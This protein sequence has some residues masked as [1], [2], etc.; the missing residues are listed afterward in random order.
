MSDA[1]AATGGTAATESSDLTFGPR[2]ARAREALSLSVNDLAA[3]LRLNPKQVIAIEREDLAALPGPAFARGFV[4][5]YAKEVRIDPAPLIASLNRR[6]EPAAAAEASPVNAPL[7]RTAERE[8]LSRTLVIAGAIGALIVFAVIGWIANTTRSRQAAAPPAPAQAEVGATAGVTPLAAGTD[9]VAALSPQP[10]QTGAAAV[11][12]ASATSAALPSRAPD[13]ASEP[14][15]LRF[16][17]RDASWV[18]VTQKD[19][20]VLLTQN[21]PAGSEQVVHGKPPYRVVI[22]NASAVTLEYEGKPIDLKPVTRAGNVA[23][24]TVQ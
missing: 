15:T 8:R 6:L 11:A 17:F 14:G 10:S 3:R 23:R 24:L 21:N 19:G 22:G 7:L 12:P 4:R 16:A 9:P 1:G 2:L 5:N 13:A 20:K 18:E